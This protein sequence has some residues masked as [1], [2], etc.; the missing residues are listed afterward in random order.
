[1]YYLISYDL[2]GTDTEEYTK[3]NKAITELNG[4]RILRT[5]WIIYRAGT[6][7]LSIATELDEFIDEKIEDKLVVVC[8]GNAL[9]PTRFA[10]LGLGSVLEIL[11]EL[12]KGN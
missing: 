1:M 11:K 4:V 5:V 8:F 3:I 7:S 12:K 10:Q 6:S 9:D 2:V